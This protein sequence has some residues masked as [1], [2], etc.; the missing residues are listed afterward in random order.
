[1]WGACSTRPT[2]AHNSVAKF[3]LENGTV[4]VRP[5]S[6]A[7]TRCSCPSPHH[8]LDKCEPAA[9]PFTQGGPC[10]QVWHESGTLVGEPAFVPAPN[11]TAEDDGVVLCV[12]VQADGTSAMLVLD[13]RSLA[14]VARC[15][16][17]YQLTIGFHGTFLA[18]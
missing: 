2:N 5:G 18:T 10:L 6:A 16:V 4:E 1:M 14:E 7:C 11:A 15:T 17:P 8:F 3:D 9:A 12:L 13:G